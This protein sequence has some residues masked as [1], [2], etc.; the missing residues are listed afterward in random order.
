MGRPR[1]VVPVL[2]PLS[3]ARNQ[4]FCRDRVQ[5]HYAPSTLAN[6]NS[7]IRM[8]EDFIRNN[9][10]L[11]AAFPVQPSG[12]GEFIAWWSQQAS[13]PRIKHIVSTLN[14][15]QQDLPEAY[16]PFSPTLKR[17]LYRLQRGL[18]KMF[19]PV[20]VRKRPMTLDRILSLVPFL[21]LGDSWDLQVLTMMFVAHDCLLRGIELVS[22]RM[23]DIVWL[24][25][26]DARVCIRI[27]KTT[28]DRAPEWVDLIDYP[29]PAYPVRINGARLLRAFW[30]FRHS[31]GATAD[32]LLFPSPPGRRLSA[33]SSLK[34]AF[35]A[36][37]Q[38]LAELAGL[39]ADDFSGHSFRSGGATDLWAS[40]ADPVSVKTQGRWRSETFWLY[41][42]DDPAVHVETVRRAFSNVLRARCRSA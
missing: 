33:P 17:F 23:G 5:A 14:T 28:H 34:R 25:S 32:A 36:R 21:D 26:G 3:R 27:S 40:G 19:R 16:P 12:I 11:P 22:L 4:A 15:H 2:S 37:V 20:V 18:N 7:I 41:V 29:L 24:P 1:K 42:R 6:R 30:D 35:V 31:Q 13:S 8:Y 10:A 39:E 9:T 38:E